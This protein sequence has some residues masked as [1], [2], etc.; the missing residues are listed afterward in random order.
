MAKKEAETDLLV[1][2]LLN[3]ADIHLTPQ[4]CGILEINEAL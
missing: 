4:G 2:K 1:Y 3:E